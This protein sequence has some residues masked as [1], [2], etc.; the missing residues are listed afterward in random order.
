MHYGWP[1]FEELGLWGLYRGKDDSELMP[2]ILNYY[3]WTCAWL[4]KLV[5]PAKLAEKKNSTPGLFFRSRCPLARA[6]TGAISRGDCCHIRKFWKFL[7]G[8]ISTLKSVWCTICG[9]SLLPAYSL[10]HKVIYCQTVEGRIYIS[11][12]FSRVD[13]KFLSISQGDILLSWHRLW[14][15]GISFD[16]KVLQAD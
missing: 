14:H 1:N 2:T 11:C 8:N 3:I 9:V 12:E 16:H 5:S 13:R 15:I 4:H 10:N 6:C 7:K